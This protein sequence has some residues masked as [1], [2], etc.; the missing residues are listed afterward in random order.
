MKSQESEY[1]L[2]I[3]V[4]LRPLVNCYVVKW[5]LA[6]YDSHTGQKL[7]TTLIKLARNGG[8]MSLKKRENHGSDHKNLQFPFEETVCY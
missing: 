4:F 7:K 6:D 3:T 5:V 1:P 2:N 8:G